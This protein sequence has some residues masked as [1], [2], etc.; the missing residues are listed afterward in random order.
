[1]GRD[2]FQEMTHDILLSIKSDIVIYLLCSL[3]CGVRTVTALLRACIV[4]TAV[5]L[6]I[7]LTIMYT[8]SA[9]MQAKQINWN[10]YSLCS[11]NISLF[12]LLP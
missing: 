11:G 10:V 6:A 12:F 3:G 2:Q 8:V 4:R 9:G 7:I 5:I 1:M